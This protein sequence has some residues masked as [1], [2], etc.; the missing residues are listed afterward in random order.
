[1]LPLA[2]LTLIG[3]AK[4]GSVVLAA[5]A[6]AASSLA[7]S[8]FAALGI[9]AIHGLLVLLASRS[10]LLAFSGAVRIVVIG[11]LVLA[12]P[13]VTRLP[14]TAGAFEANAWWLAWA[15]PAWF[16]GLERWLLGDTTRGMLAAQAMAAT[17]GA[18]AIAVFAY[19]RLYRRFDRVT[20]QSA[21]PVRSP[22]GRRRSPGGAGARRSGARYSASSRSRSSGA[23]SIRAW[24]SACWR[25]RA[26]WC[27]T[28]C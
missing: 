21:G 25:G 1:M 6:F 2:A 12:L 13:L 7:A 10:R 16:A 18:V 22:A 17:I 19:V 24:S 20:F 23:S 26:A 3:A 5:V 9:V 4:T 15:P 27:S 8:L 28:A 11:G 14:A